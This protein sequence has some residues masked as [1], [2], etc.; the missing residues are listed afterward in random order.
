M[1]IHDPTVGVTA[2]LTVRVPLGASGTLVEGVARVL[3]R[4]D[5]V[6]DVEDAAVTGVSPGLNDTAVDTTVTV[7]VETADARGDTTLAAREV[8]ADGF[9]VDDVET[10]E[11][12]GRE[13]PDAE[14]TAGG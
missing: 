11:L 6:L 12:T 8:L 3:E 7:T 9:G 5:R 14:V 10:V 2:D 13:P 4:N 1:A